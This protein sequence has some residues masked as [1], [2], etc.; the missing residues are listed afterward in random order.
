MKAKIF[1]SIVN[2]LDMVTPKLWYCNGEGHTLTTIEQIP[3]LCNQKRNG[4]YSSPGNF[5]GL[6]D[7]KVL[8]LKKSRET[9]NAALT[10]FEGSEMV[11]NVETILINEQLRIF[12][13]VDEWP[14]QIDIL[15]VGA[16]LAWETF[17]S[18]YFPDDFVL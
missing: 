8:A 1:C 3:A 9:G 18:Y 17:E 7:E 10:I 12:I 16:V 5:S 13:M 4:I 15:Y 11:L 14:A 2:N 6:A